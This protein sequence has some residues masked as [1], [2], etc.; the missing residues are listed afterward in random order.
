MSPLDLHDGQSTECIRADG[1]SVNMTLNGRSWP[2]EGAQLGTSPVTRRAN[3]TE[4]RDASR[5][6]RQAH[7]RHAGPRPGVARAMHARANHHTCAWP[8][9][10]SHHPAYPVSVTA[11]CHICCRRCFACAPGH[12][13]LPRSEQAVPRGS[14]MHR[15]VGVA[16]A[17]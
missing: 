15:H 17:A 4:V 6:R 12:P 9:P 11:I 14:S 1:I 16:E 8:P 5:H 3:A 10:P 2:A 7:P 13:Q